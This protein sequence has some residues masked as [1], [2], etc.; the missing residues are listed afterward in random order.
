MSVPAK[1]HLTPFNGFSRVRECERRHIQ[2]DGQTDRPRYG[3]VCRDRRNVFQ[4]CRLKRKQKFRY[5]YYI[6][7]FYLLKNK[8]KRTFNKLSMTNEQDNKAASCTYS[9]PWKRLVGAYA[10]GPAYSCTLS[11]RIAYLLCIILSALS[12]LSCRAYARRPCYAARHTHS[13]LAALCRYSADRQT[14]TRHDLPTSQPD[15][16]RFASTQ[17]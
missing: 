16:S 11:T 3:N 12:R 15:S 13:G 4:R 1:W 17:L 7:T 6:Y 9:C 8:V 2:T 5:L 10:R 14:D